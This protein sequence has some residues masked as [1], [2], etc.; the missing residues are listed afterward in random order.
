VRPRSSVQA[1]VPAIRTVLVSVVLL[2]VFGALFA[3]ADALFAS[4]VDALTPDISWNDLPAR[5]VLAVFVAGGTL[6]AAFVALAPPA[7]D[8]LQLPLKQ[9]RRDFEWLAPV[10]VVNAVF[11]LFLVAQATA[12]FGGHDYLQRTTGLTYADYVHEGFGQLTV[13]TIL[14]LT[15]VAWAARKA[16]PGRRRDLALGALCV[17]TLVVVASALHRMGLYEEAYGFSRLRL[18][19]SV[20]EGW[21]GVV[22][23]LVLATRVVRARQWL[24]PAAVRLGALGLLGLAVLN[25]DLWI[26]EHNLSRTQATTPVDYQYLA[27]L[28]PDAAPALVGVTAP[29]V[30]C[31]ARAGRGSDWLEWNLGRSHAADL[32]SRRTD[33]GLATCLLR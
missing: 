19:V 21:L 33:A 4:W 3:S 12:L 20:F 18:L 1:W 27:E 22:V 16:A 23:L 6:A 17:M 28:S 7:V 32:V 9:S 29:G 10:S 14:T 13:A 24:V 2:L 8:R 11:A 30:T 15:V 31:P 26:A 25:P 5:A